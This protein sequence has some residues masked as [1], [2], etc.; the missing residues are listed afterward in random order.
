MRPI[1]AAVVLC[2]LR[3]QGAESGSGPEVDAAPAEALNRRSDGSQVRTYRWDFEVVDSSGRQLFS[4]LKEVPIL[5]D[6]KQT[7]P[8]WVQDFGAAADPARRDRFPREP[9][10]TFSSISPRAG[11]RS[12]HIYSRGDHALI[13]LAQPLAAAGGGAF[14]A[15]GWIRLKGLREAS[16]QLRMGF[17]GE[18]LPASERFIASDP[19]RGEGDWKS[20][21]LEGRI[22][23]SA[24]SAD[25]QILLSGSYHD[26]EMHA[27]ID[28]LELEI[29]PG[30][31]LHWGG[32]RLLL[33]GEE[34]PDIVFSL[35]AGG[36]APG[37]Y[38]LEA[39]LQPLCLDPAAPPRQH[40]DYSCERFA[41][42]GDGE[43]FGT[44]TSH[45][46][47]LRFRGNLREMFASEKLPR[48]LHDL[49]IR[50]RG[51]MAGEDRR[52]A[53][54]AASYTER[55]GILPA[56]REPL[57]LRGVRMGWALSGE[58]L[59]R[60]DL[61]VLDSLPKGFALDELLWDLSGEGASQAEIEPPPGVRLR[62]DRRPLHWRG[63]LGPA[64]LEDPDL[65]IRRLL[66]ASRTLRSWAIS[67]DPANDKAAQAIERV[68]TS[69]DFMALGARAGGARPPWAS[70]R[71]H[72]V[73]PSRNA[74][75]G[76][77]RPAE[78]K[79]G[80][81]RG[82]GKVA[83]EAPEAGDWT[84][85][86]R[87]PLS[88]EREDALSFSR[89]L[90]ELAAGGHRRIFWRGATQLWKLDGPGDR[91]APS[92][93]AFAW[94][95]LGRALAGGVVQRRG[96][97]DA[98]GEFYIIGNGTER[99][100]VALSAGAGA[101][102]FR[103]WTGGPVEGVDLYGDPV[104]AAYDSETGESEISVGPEPVRYHGIDLLLLDTVESVFSS[105]G[106]LQ[107]RRGV[108]PLEFR[109]TNHT[110]E[111]LGVRLAIRL[112]SNWRLEAGPPSRAVAPGE[113]A[114]LP[115][116]VARRESAGRA[117]VK[118][119]LTLDVERG[120]RR[121]TRR[122]ELALAVE[123][124]LIKLSGESIDPATRRL[125]FAVGNLSPRPLS[126]RVFCRL[127][128]DAGRELIESWDERL[129]PR[130]ERI[131]ELPLD[132]RDD[133]L[134]GKVV[135]LGL[136]ASGYDDSISKEFTV[137][138]AGDRLILILLPE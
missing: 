122:R 82:S 134:D 49:E 45:A 22:P 37:G 32:R 108:Q 12:L 74:A 1:A 99:F 72:E 78:P 18:R 27:W 70:F 118:A 7:Q 137:R 98:R 113:T 88:G 52:D 94:C 33:F 25:L 29:G 130:A 10:A 105:A 126:L 90:L 111:P 97:F 114:R 95:A 69:F 124:P 132:A 14:R 51:P 103:A 15:H 83:T 81:E 19:L 23:D 40:L 31:R 76:G 6:G 50:I 2:I 21:H 47:P 127:P 119:E 101:F 9:M 59:R 17:R 56:A 26:R 121:F 93:G 115:F 131:L 77:A 75:A 46:A 71:V 48:G 80:P 42:T 102:S 30:I 84:I 20:I 104:S 86:E 53:P 128:L 92:R 16:V 79:E 58:D 43:G 55:L 106:T 62:G 68:R 135:R 60:G 64:M 3:A 13:R 34:E 44:P 125:R 107:S 5:L 85:V 96:G 36:L 67:A 8:H 109:L 100:L 89:L 120:G 110:S 91:L 117:F 11:H 129:A 4:D 41:S 73:N 28:S 35:D 65:L 63:R 133:V 123:S 138:R 87:M 116:E 61:Q 38:R 54:V 39:A 112:P 57:C 66:A 136:E 24:A